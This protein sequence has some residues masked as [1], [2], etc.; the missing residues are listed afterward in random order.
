[1]QIQLM[2]IK[3]NCSQSSQQV[4]LTKVEDD[5]PTNSD[6]TLDIPTPHFRACIEAFED[7][8]KET[9][10]VTNAYIINAIEVDWFLDLGA[11]FHV[12]SSYISPT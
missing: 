11:S 2:T 6:T 9:I 7:N 8:P 5:V 4:H 1:M 10:E 3:R 12:T